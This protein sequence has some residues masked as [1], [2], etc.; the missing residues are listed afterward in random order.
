VWNLRQ[1]RALD[2]QDSD[3]E[4]F[5]LP[6]SME[7]DDERQDESEENDTSKEPSSDGKTMDSG[8]EPPLL[9]MSHVSGKHHTSWLSSWICFPYYICTI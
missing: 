6:L 9:S 7:S 5:V 1:A 2:P 3:E 8:N 4:V